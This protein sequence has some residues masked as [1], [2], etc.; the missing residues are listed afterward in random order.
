MTRLLALTLLIGFFAFLPSASA[1]GDNGLHIIPADVHQSAS[2][3]TAV[4]TLN[5]S[6][7]Q[8]RAKWRL[9]GDSPF[10]ITDHGEL[11][12]TAEMSDPATIV[13][14]VIVEDMFSELNQRLSKF[15]GNGINH[16]GVYIGHLADWLI[17]RRDCWRLPAWAEP[18]HS[19]QAA[20]WASRFLV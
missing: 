16:R 14:T 9:D 20:V 6:N 3:G 10:A 13:A 15:G 5:V 2:G 11:R 7:I 18:W 4:L 17:R 19:K 12:L 1:D 8:V